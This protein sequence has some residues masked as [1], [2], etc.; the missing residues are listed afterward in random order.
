[1]SPDPKALLGRYRQLA[2]S[3]SFYDNGGNFLDT[4]NAYQDGQSEVWVG[5][6]IASRK[7]RD[8]LVLAT[9]YT[10]PYKAHCKDTIQANYT[11]NGSKS[12][13]LSLEDSLRKLQTTYIDLF[14]VHWWD[15]TT[16]IPEMMQSLNHL[17]VSGNVP[18]LGLLLTDEE[19]ET[20][21]S[22]YDFDHG[23]P[24]SFLSGTLFDRS[25]PRGAYGPGDVWLTKSSGPFDWVENSKPIRPSLS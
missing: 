7:N 17:V 19:I 21:E 13:A 2:P 20:I 8:D 10:S 18:A 15:Y 4:A 24:H 22:A 5:E 25:K 3:A 1:M 6:W 11:G 23:F 14:Y 16:S 9:K 12:M